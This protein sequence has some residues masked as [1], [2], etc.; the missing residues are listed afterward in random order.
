MS[1][2]AAF[3]LLIIILLAFTFDFI[4]GFHDTA[5]AVATSIATGALSPQLAIILAATMNFL[6]ALAFTGVAQTIAGNILQPLS[7][8]NGLKIILAALISASIWNLVTW[9]FGLP[10]SS[11]HALFGS[12]AGAAYAAGRSQD[13]DYAGLQNALEALVV[14]PL[15]AFLAGFCVMTFFNLL[16]YFQIF[17]YPDHRF[18]FLQRIAATLQ[19]F[20]HGSND[21]QKTMGVITLALITAGYQDSPQV[22]LWVKSASAV[23]IALG[24]AT[25]GW[26]IIKTVATGLTRLG[27]AS[28]F[29]ADLSS[30]LT[31]FSATIL[32]LPVSTTHV[33]SSAIIGVGATGGKSAVKWATAIRMLV[34]WA[35]TLPLVTFMGVVI[36][37]LL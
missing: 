3:F 27:P 9:Y 25:G 36:Y 28:G 4:N 26:R 21:A 12:L 24:T 10:S 5:N 2:Q 35:F 16:F 17:S 8:E 29:A 13:I 20:S 14:S 30:A 7:A 15:L 6:G 32:H 1:E 23:M 19:A 22:P 18:L 37:L 33:I 34:A 11:S 31:I